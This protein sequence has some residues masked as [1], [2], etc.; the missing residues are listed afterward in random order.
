MRVRFV[1]MML[2]CAAVAGAGGLRGEDEL[3]GIAAVIKK[4]DERLVLVNVLPGGPA[5]SA[6]LL[7]GDELLTIDRVAVAYFSLQELAERLRGEPH[8]TVELLVRRDNGLV[9]VTY[10]VMRKTFE[11]PETMPTSGR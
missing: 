11:V 2:A 6:G 7:A 10:R 1:A 9:P 3:T 5:E 8:S 4:Q